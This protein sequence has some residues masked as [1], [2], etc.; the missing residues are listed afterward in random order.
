MAIPYSA[1]FV[2]RELKNFNPIECSMRTKITMILRIKFTGLDFMTDIIEYMR[3]P[4]N[5]VVIVNE[6]EDR[7]P[8]FSTEKIKVKSAKSKDC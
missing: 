4:Q 6:E 3:N 2:V 1:C 5:V 7:L 8:K